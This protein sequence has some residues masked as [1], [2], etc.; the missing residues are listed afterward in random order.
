MYSEIKSY[1]N[2]PDTIESKGGHVDPSPAA[3]RSAEMASVPY[4]GLVS[5]ALVFELFRVNLFIVIV[6]D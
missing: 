1:G 6:T 2:F 5:K 4:M 3:D